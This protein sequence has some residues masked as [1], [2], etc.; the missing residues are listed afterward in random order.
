MVIGAALSSAG[1]LA[2]GQR[3][4]SESVG[5]TLVPAT[6]PV[7][8]LTYRRPNQATMRK[9]FDGLSD[10]LSGRPTQA[11][12]ALATSCRVPEYKLEGIDEQIAYSDPIA[13]LL[14]DP[15]KLSDEAYNCLAA[16]VRPPYLT[17][18]KVEL[19]SRI[20]GRA[21]APPCPNVVE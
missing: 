1:W 21:N 5:P 20:M 2:A 13:R 9:V 15:A 4:H 18:A 6:T 17:L 7:F 8:E 11:L 3:K 16:R 12:L 10:P 19:C 14:I